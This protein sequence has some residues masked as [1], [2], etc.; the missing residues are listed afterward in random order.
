MNIIVRS[1]KMDFIRKLMEN[2][3]RALKTAPNVNNRISARFAKM[4]TLF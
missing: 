4:D 2:A 1:V 3:N